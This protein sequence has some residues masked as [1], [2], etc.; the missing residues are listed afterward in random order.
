MVPK[1]FVLCGL[2]CLSLSCDGAIH[3]K[4]KVYVEKTSKAD[5][6]AFV[7]ESSPDVSGLTPLKE[8]TVTLYHGGD[9]SRE[10][11]NKST[12]WKDS[13]K[14]DSGGSFELGGTTSPFPFHAALVVE[15]V[16]YKPVTKIFVHEKI[17]PHY[18]VIILS[19]TD[20]S[21]K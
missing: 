14:S 1:T 8:V 4:G 18:A 2:A 19:P 21:S 20:K 10:P 6:K 17:A 5:S 13:A 9:Y 3:V 12:L 11:I 15:E 7:D 16:G